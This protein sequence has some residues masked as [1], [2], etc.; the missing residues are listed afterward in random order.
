MI[1]F[2]G[3]SRD[4]PDS[5]R[6]LGKPRLDAISLLKHN[7]PQVGANV[8]F[9][10]AVPQSV[11]TAPMP[12]HDLV[13]APFADRHVTTGSASIVAPIVTVTI[14]VTAVRSDTEVQLCKRNVGLGRDSIP[15]IS[16]YAGNCRHRARAGGNKRK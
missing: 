7:G 3:S 13:A 2:S 12:D 5:F 1:W 6:C 14:A 15:S 4:E 11:A 10:A 9:K 16:S 8:L